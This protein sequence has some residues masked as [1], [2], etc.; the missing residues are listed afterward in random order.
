M[1][2]LERLASESEAESTPAASHP[3]EGKGNGYESGGDLNDHSVIEIGDGDKSFSASDEDAES[4]VDLPLAERLKRRA[5]RTQLG[6]ESSILPQ[7]G[8]TSKDNS[9]GMSGRSA[10]CLSSDSDYDSDMFSGLGFLDDPIPD[11]PIKSPKKKS[12]GPHAGYDCLEAPP[13]QAKER[14]N[15]QKRKRPAASSALRRNQ[16]RKERPVPET[17]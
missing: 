11:S 4:M 17:W 1:S 10:Q 8:D 3:R 7:A 2:S 15:D 12:P 5:S 6:A 14:E 9:N 16:K 13:G